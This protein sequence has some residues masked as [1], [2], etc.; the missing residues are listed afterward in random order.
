MQS[1]IPQSIRKQ[2]AQERARLGISERKYVNNALAH[3][4]QLLAIDRELE[5]EL[6]MWNEASAAD[7]ATFAKKHR[8]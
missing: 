3:Y 1:V 7:F 6:T 4:R 5:K 2:V 8:L